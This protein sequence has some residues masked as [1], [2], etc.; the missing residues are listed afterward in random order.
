MGLPHGEVVAEPN[1]GRGTCMKV[2][3]RDRVTGPAPAVIVS[4]ERRRTK[5]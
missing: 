3:S 1:R 4:N 5:K 2:R